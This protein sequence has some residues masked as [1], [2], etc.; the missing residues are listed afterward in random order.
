MIYRW[1][2][3]FSARIALLAAGAGY[4]A[5]VRFFFHHLP[6]PDLHRQVIWMWLCWG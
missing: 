3:E 5:D 4:H 2:I 6:L 1:N